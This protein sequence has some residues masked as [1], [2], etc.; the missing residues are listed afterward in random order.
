MGADSK[1]YRLLADIVN[2]I[3][4]TVN[5]ISAFLPY[6]VR[7]YVYAISS[8]CWSIVGIAGS[9]TRTA[10]TIHQARAN[11]AADVQV[12]LSENFRLKSL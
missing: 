1:R 9:C 12:F 7:P 4:L 3:A 6:T 10:L 2:D 11:N 8:I 5:L